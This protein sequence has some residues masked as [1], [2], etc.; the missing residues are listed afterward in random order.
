MCPGAYRPAVDTTI[1]VSVDDRSFDGPHGPVRV[2]VYRPSRGDAHRASLP[3]FVWCHGGGWIGGDLDMVEAH[4]TSVRIAQQLPGVVVS[5]EYRL[6]PAHRFPVPVDDIVAAWRGVHDDAGELGI[7]TARVALGGASAG[8]H[9]TAL[10]LPQLT[11]RPKAFVAVYPATDPDAG[12]YVDRPAETAPEH[13]LDPPTIRALWAELH[14]PDQSPTDASVPAR[15]D[16]TAFP[17]TLVTTAGIDSL[18]PQAERFV[19]LL[20]AAGVDVEHH[21]E[22][23]AHHGYL[24]LTGHSRRATAALDRHVDWLRDALRRH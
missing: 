11:P 4:D 22:P 16:L 3:G 1:E 24:S 21:H 20:R 9:L 14:G 18:T 19:E 17:P 6:A 5:V 13:W 7:D 23:W 2:R 8:G 15:Q 10:A 12:P